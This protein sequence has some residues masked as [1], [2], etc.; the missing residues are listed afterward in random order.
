MSTDKSGD[1][2]SGEMSRADRDAIRQRAS[3]LGAKLDQAKHRQD[4]PSSASQGAAMGQGMR[5]AAELI[6]GVVAGGAIGWFLDA[7]LGSRPWLFI[8]F[9]LLGTAAGMRNIIRQAQRVK[10]PPAPSV[11]DDDEAET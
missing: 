11:K 1:R 6:G 7:W 9:F 8:V 5:I 3:E 4:K 2:P 10:T